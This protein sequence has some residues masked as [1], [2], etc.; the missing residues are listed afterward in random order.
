MAGTIVPLQM[1]AHSEN[2]LAGS[3][4]LTNA[5]DYLRL[6]NSHLASGTNKRELFECWATAWIERFSFANGAS[7]PGKRT[8]RLCGYRHECQFRASRY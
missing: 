5:V 6:L 3:P 7:S 8:C 2:D 1:V 4:I